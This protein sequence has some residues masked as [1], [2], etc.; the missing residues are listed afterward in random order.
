[1]KTYYSQLNIVVFI[2]ALIVI[3]S[4]KQGSAGFLYA[5][6]VGINIA[7][8]SPNISAILDI[9]AQPGFNKG[10][11]IPRVTYSQRI[12]ANFNP[13]SAAAQGLTVYQTDAGGLGEGFYFN[14][15]TSTTPAWSFL[16]N[17]TS[18]W[19]LTGN[20][21][22]TP[23]TSAIGTAIA[24][25]QNYVGTSDLKD[26]V[27]ATNNLERL[28][29]S[30]A[31]NIG[32][33]TSTPGALLDVN[34]STRALLYTF[35]APT[36]DPAPVITARTVPSGQGASSEKTELILFHSN[37]PATVAGADQITLRAPALSFQTFSDINVL[38]INN[39]AGFNE[40]MY[41]NSI[42]NV[43]IGTTIPSGKV[44]AIIGSTPATT[45]ISRISNYSDAFYLTR[46]SNIGKQAIVFRG[47]DLIG[48]A[49]ESGRQNENVD[50]GTY[51]AFLTRNE[52]TSGNTNDINEKMRITGNGNVGIGTTAPNEK[53]EVVGNAR[54]TFLAGNGIRP[55][56]ADANGSLTNSTGGVS[57]GGATV[58]PIATFGG[59]PMINST[60]WQ[61]VTRTT[62]TSIAN[63]FSG[64]ATPTGATRKYYLVIRR[65]DTQPGGT[66]SF[67]RFSC[68]GAWNGGSDVPGHGFSLGSNWGS[69]AEGSTDWIEIPPSAV[70][71]AGCGTSYWKI[72]A[73]I[74]NNGQSLRVMSVSMA[75]MDVYGGTNTAYAVATSGTSS[76]PA[77]SWLGENVWTTGGNIGIGTTVPGNGKLTVDH[78]DGTYGIRMDRAGTFLFGIHN[79]GSS[80]TV[81][82]PA[83][84]RDLAVRINGIDHFTVKPSGNVGIG[85]TS[86]GAKLEIAG[87]IKITGGAPGAG[88]V[89][90]SDAAGLAT[91]NT[92]S[93]GTVTGSGTLNYVPKWTPDGSTLGNSQLFDNATN[94]GIGTNAPGTKL[95][96]SGGSISLGNTGNSFEVNR[97]FLRFSGCCNDINH[98]IYNNYLNIDGEGVW[99]GMKMNV[100]NGLNVRVGNGGATSALFINPSALVGIGTTGPTEKLTVAGN[101]FLTA[102][103]SEIYGTD[104]NHMLVLRGDQAGTTADMTSY[105][106]YG[107]TLA[108]GLGHRFFT[109]GV[110]ASQ[111][112]KMRIS[113]DG[114]YML[115]NVGIGTITP[116]TSNGNVGKLLEISNT[117]VNQNTDLTLSTLGTTV[118]GSYSIL[119]A[120]NRSQTAGE[121]RPGQLAFGR[122]NTSTTA[123]DGYM[124]IW[125]TQGGAI[126][127]RVRILSNGNV[128]IGT[129]SPGYK[130][131]VPS[132]YI[133]TDYINTS[134]NAV[135]S[136]LTGI[137]VKQ[138]DNYHRTS[139]AAGVLSFLGVTAPNGDNLGNHVA[140]TTL[141]M[142]GNVISNGAAFY[143]TI[144][145]DQNNSAFYVDPNGNTLLNKLR[146][147][148][149]GT[150]S[151]QWGHDPYGYGWGAPAAS[152]RN[153]EVSSSGNYSTEPAMFRIHQW[154][155]GA[156]EFWKP[157]GT[158]L[159]LRETPG[160]GGGWFNMFEVQGQARVTSNFYAPIMYDNNDATY[161]V[162]PASTSNL[163][164]F[165]RGTLARSSINALQDN[166]P[167]TTRSVQIDNYKNGSMGWGQVDFNVITNWGSGFIDTWSNPPNAPGGSS[168]YTGI[169]S[170][171][172]TSLNSLN[173]YGFQMVTAG[174][175]ANRYFLRNSWNVPRPWVEMIHTG[176][177]GSYGDNLGN[178]TATATL[179]MNGNVISNGAAFYSTILYDQNNSA[180]Y[181]DPNGNTLLNKLRVDQNGT[182]SGQWGHDPYGY[183]WGAPAASFRNLEVSSSGNYSTEP[184]MFRIHQ[185]GSGSAEFWKPQGTQLYLRE[186]P[187]GGGGWF[188]RFIVQG[189]QVVHAG[190]MP[191]GWDQVDWG[192]LVSFRRPGAGNM[193]G[194]HHG[195]S[196]LELVSEGAGTAH[197]AFHRPGI[198]GA[199]FGLDNDNWFSTQGWSAGGGYTS[200]R[201]GSLS[202]FGKQLVTRGT[203]PNGW[204]VVDWG[205]LSSLR[206]P[207]A[208]NMAGAHHGN[209]QLELVSEGAGTAHIAFHR[210][211]IFGA[212]FGLDNDNWFSTQGWSAGGGYTSM[213]VGSLR[214]NSGDMFINYTGGGWGGGGGAHTQLFFGDDE[215]PCGYKLIHANS[216]V[217]GFH[218]GCGVSWL[219]YWDNA[220]NQQN[221]GVVF[222]P[223]FQYSSDV[224]LKKD[225]RNL[226]NSIE[227]LSALQGV[228][229]TWKATG[230]PSIGFIAQDVEKV[231]PEVVSTSATT[232]L[233]S[234]SYG[235]L[236][237]PLIEA[238]KSQQET[239]KKQ[240]E[241]IDS[242]KKLLKQLESEVREK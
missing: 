141:N 87:Q 7:G 124:A 84:T 150:T 126:G 222:A 152:F 93:T 225:I 231:Y 153:L 70:S 72:D 211:G 12:G 30:S 170:M 118:D 50:W 97:G 173:F 100:Y 223:G 191:N 106:Q 85:T 61:R 60:S 215:S 199:N 190:A 64:I 81:L 186:T 227:K 55:V 156:A 17:N 91:W 187:G 32:I 218:G 131:H 208:G 19:S 68:E 174:E 52:N 183:G 167:V 23:S 31:G 158:T 71:A 49:I 86:P 149:N 115:G 155:S 143:S 36:G 207:G 122:S 5:Q 78:S 69:A 220:G 83:G 25:G 33:G 168:H 178:H 21:T 135:S 133:G 108:S 219:A 105:Y 104:R 241:E 148:Q 15:S 210:P 16:L 58:I 239:I 165:T 75:I 228:S 65:A 28:R 40:R 1:M 132:G 193:A 136:G 212:N 67:W 202:V 90:T 226:E 125:T 138:G 88:K 109:G 102:G 234:V 43:G 200:M 162:D 8:A 189:K 129:T 103:R 51:F 209:S 175:S 177:I 182:T 204:D 74:A 144:L 166:S 237:A 201:V 39:N 4:M 11:L 184:A 41:I 161:Y 128:G 44:E 29:I 98:T 236:V 139:N 114:I 140:T 185:W 188:T 92:P 94:V 62:Y 10:L 79:N 38:D 232:G 120:I 111:T 9:D 180:F 80:Q 18:G 27:L 206:S 123:L 45:A 147:D 112:E 172:Q 110:V 196:Q 57:Q 205:A 59:E 230:E 3:P 198:F 160:G 229:F 214:V 113:N 46:S 35:P 96:V 121:N 101:I 26:F 137:M 224:T 37:D 171:H 77:L 54:I 146:V 154:G 233:K 176:N 240:Q 238:V 34:G 164:L 13:L 2:L 47:S 53:L 145:Y 192:A 48:A 66:G 14:T 169:Q 76:Y 142:N 157:Q 99:D 217:I 119:T 24:A 117:I 6:N 197:I 82:E 63:L 95:Q 203:I 20:A 130:L 181:V 89:L 242:I 22:T 134:D 179:N 213:R 116:T 127:E 107:G 159:F 195:N 42:G 221:I 56:Y 194:A 151:G 163:N 216:N 235:S 73:R